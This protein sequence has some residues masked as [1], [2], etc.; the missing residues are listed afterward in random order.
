[1]HR[2]GARD[3][4]L[5]LAQLAPRLGR[6]ISSS[7]ERDVASP[8]SLRQYRILE[9]L[10]ERPYRTGELASQ[11][12]V[13]Q[14]SV[15][16]SVAALESRGLIRRTPDPTDGRATL[17]VLTDQGRETLERAH[18]RLVDLLTLVTLE[19][20]RED[21]AALSKMQQRLNEGIDRARSW[22]SDPGRA[23]DATSV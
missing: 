9:R 22:L 20:E 8:L 19:A 7:L 14:A 15:S 6:L 10:A 1:M 3:A 18:D 21:A 13:S 4:A 5:V 2:E 23:D 17:V 12:E 16:T 11:S